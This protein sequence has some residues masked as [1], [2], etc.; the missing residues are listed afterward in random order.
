MKNIY[1]GLNLVRV[2]TG[3]ECQVSAITETHAILYW[4]HTRSNTIV[5]LKRVSRPSEY[6]VHPSSVRD[7][8]GV[9]LT[10]REQD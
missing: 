6:Q 2:K 8:K 1:P 3:H 9:P 7:Y 4:P 10:A 5:S